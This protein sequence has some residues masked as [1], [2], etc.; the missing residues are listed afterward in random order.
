[1]SSALYQ[2]VTLGIVMAAATTINL[3]F[4]AAFGITVP[5]VMNKFGKDPALG[6]SV[7]L[8]FCTDSMGFFIF[9][10]LASIFL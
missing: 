7:I 10:G 3:V 2:N 4:A 9:L 8:T 6:S 5:L 1:V